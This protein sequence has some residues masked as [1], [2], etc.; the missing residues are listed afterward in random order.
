[1][2]KYRVCYKICFCQHKTIEADSFLEA[3]KEADIQIPE[4]DIQRAWPGASICIADVSLLENQP[5]K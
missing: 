5:E 2:N 3:I 4:L 1:M